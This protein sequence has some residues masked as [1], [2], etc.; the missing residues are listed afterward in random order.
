MR[1]SS[2][3][4]WLR[5][6]SSPRKTASKKPYFRKC[7]LEIL[8]DRTL[9]SAQIYTVT[10]NGDAG[11]KDTSDPSGHSGDVRYCINQANQVA[12]AGS[13]I[14]FDP[15]AIFG[16]NPTGTI[17][18]SHG[19]LPVK[20]N[21]TIQG[22]SVGP[23]IVTIS[24]I[25]GG[26]ASR[27]FDITSSVAKV[28]ISDLTIADGNAEPANS[29]VP[30]NQGGDIFNGGTLVLSNDI[31]TN[32]LSVGTVGG[33]NGRG[34]AIYNAEGTSGI[35]S[36]ATLILDNTIVEN[37]VARGIAG[38]IAEGGGVLN[39]INATLIVQNGSQI[40]NNQAIGATLDGGAA[41]GGGILNFGA[42]QLNGSSSAPIVIADNLAQG[43]TGGNGAHG[44]TPQSGPGGKGGDGLNGGDA[45][46]GGIY[47]VGSTFTLQ[48]VHF[49]GNQANAG[50]G[51][52]GGTG[53]NAAGNGFSG[54][55]GGKG[56]KGGSA[57]GGGIYNG[58]SALIVPN[59]QFG[60]D[61]NGVGN[62]VNSG[63]G[64]NGGNGGNGTSGAGGGVGGKGTK[65]GDG[66]QALGGAM[67]NFGGSVSFTN[68]SFTSSLAR[69]GG[70]GNSGSGGSGGN[71]TNNGAKGAKGGLGADGGRGGDA[72]GGGLFNE[73]SKTSYSL[74]MTNGTFAGNQAVAGAGGAGGAGGLAG[75]GG[76]GNATLTGGKGGSGS[77][78]GA[79][80]AGGN[81][82]GGGFYNTVGTV[83]IKG[84]SL[85]DNSV[86][87]G[88]GGAGGAAGNGG[89]GG[90]NTSAG[91]KAG[92]G[93]KG[94]AGGLGGN[95]G[96]AEGG[97]AG[98]QGGNMTVTGADFL[99]NLIHTST[100][101]TG[102]NGGRGGNGGNGTAIGLNGYGGTGGNGGEGGTGASALGGG[103]FV[104]AS[105][106]TVTNSIFG[107]SG[108]SNQIVGGAGGAG[109]IGGSIGIHGH[110][111]T[112]TTYGTKSSLLNPAGDGGQGGLG[113]YV[114]GGALAVTGTAETVQISGST[115]A[116]NSITSGDGGAG[117][118]GG[119]FSVDGTKGGI[120]GQGGN[121]GL[122]QGGAISLSA[123]TA[124][125][126]TL[127]SDTITTNSAKGG[128]GGAG[129]INYLPGAAVFVIGWNGFGSN[130]GNGGDGG[131]QSATEPYTYGGG[132]GGAG[133]QVLG[134]GVY[135][136]NNS[137]ASLSFR[138]NG[139]SASSN[140][141]TGGSAGSGGNAGASG[142]DNIPGGA[143][144]AG[145]AVQGGGL[146]VTAGSNAIDTTSLVDLTLAGNTITGGAGGAGG[147]GYNATGG[148][149]GNAQGGAVFTT[150]ANTTSG[151][152]STLGVTGSTLSGNQANGGLGGN[153]GSSTTPNGG[154]GGA[155]GN[156]GNADGAGLYNGDNTLMNVINSTFGGSASSGNPPSLNYNVLS[157]GLGGSGGD[158]GTATGVVKSNGGAGGAGGSV[159]GA[160]VYNAG[161][162]AI[163]INDTLVYGQ[164]VVFGIGAPGGSGAG[165]GG[166]PGAPG[167]AGT[168]LAGGYYAADA[169]NQTNLVGNSIIDLNAAAT[170]SPDV[171]GTF[172]SFGNN[173][174]GSTAGATGFIPTDQSNISAA[175][176][177]LG[178]LQNNGG[179]T[180]TDALLNNSQGKSIAIDTG[181]NLLV[182]TTFFN[183]FGTNPTDQRGTGFP[184][185][186]SPSGT[187]MV[188]VGAFEYEP[189]G[190]GGPILTDPGNQT[191]NEGDKVS[192]AIKAQNA[193]T[194]SAI[195][196]PSG[197][198]I[199]TTTGVISGTIGSYAAGSYTVTVFA[200]HNGFLSS[201]TFTWTVN[202]TTPP[203]LTV[204]SNQSNNEGDKV[205]LQI[206]AVDADTFTATGLPPGLSINNSGLITGT[207]SQP[208]DGTYTVTI[209]VTDTDNIIPAN[210][211][212]TKS[213]TWTVADN[214]P[215]SVTSPGNQSNNEGDKV[216]LQIQA[217]DADTFTATGLPP[218]LTISKTGL[219]SGTISQP[220]DGTYTVTIIGKD[221]D[222]TT[223]INT[224][225]VTFTWTVADN[226]PPS[227]TSPGNQSNKEGDKVSLQIQSVDADSIT[228]KGL[229]PGLT[230]SSSG[231]ITG[232]I[233]QPGDGTYTVTITAT[234]SDNPTSNKTTTI[235]FTWTV[236][237]N[238]PPV[239]TNPSTQNNNEGD[240]VKLAI[241][242]KD[243]D[244]FSATNLPTGLSINATTGV[245]SGTIDPRAAG[246]YTVTVKA[247]DGGNSSSVTFTWNVA[248]TTPPDI[249]NPGTQ[250]NN[251]GDSVNLAIK[252]V[253]NDPGT[254]TAT[255]LP[256][257]LSIDATTG[258]ITGNI[259]PR[260]EG[261]YSVTVTAS[262][263]G[264]PA[265]VTF[266]W[267]V[268]DTTPPSFTVSNQTSD[269]GAVISL[270]T[271]PED[272]DPGS[273]TATG[274]P[275]GLSINA[276][277][278]LITG[279]I[280]PRG[281]GTYTVT[282]KA[283][284]GNISGSTTF[285][286]TVNDTTPP[287][288]TVSDQT[289]D[290]GTVIS[291]ATN[292]DDADA[293]SITATGLPAGLSINATTGVISGTIDPRAAGTYTVILQ[294]AD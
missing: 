181:N 188:D 43:G 12:N 279:T 64:G 257:G 80:G 139:G 51:G 263:N 26:G 142:E 193:D 228:A 124:Q 104:G 35:G 281:A 38:G 150:S 3:R 70:A 137:S 83:T 76:A 121:G 227:V 59:V 224:A 114:Y 136:S 219:I 262:D 147:A 144:G 134:G 229:P 73:P 200:T 14:E 19:E 241:Q 158:A 264:H 171:L 275:K 8:E 112:P 65:A 82:Q 213:F 61:A 84:T 226:L 143:G 45:L 233:S 98:N 260:G 180:S 126:A 161:T 220:G 120:N 256:P 110:G 87:S 131:S 25:G 230:I 106:L 203:S 32:G 109:G 133:G 240:T 16:G 94:G 267:N 194:F 189:T 123:T 13:T 190:T 140:T 67:A 10:L 169:A 218:G 167:V 75:N 56:G 184:R 57:Q 237:D 160:N 148:N 214:L 17:S 102:G 192:L 182:T 156:G 130:A 258:V 186:Y 235:T 86:G 198:S 215:P 31:V 5:R 242:A 7:F 173:I 204:P 113:A 231:L 291:L 101:G 175:Q 34:G 277:T 78:G 30:G 88:A 265:S 127:N 179:L 254:F 177:N 58:T 183:L 11:T 40:V 79:G 283:T 261:T 125:S 294:A 41:E 55:P 107:E 287:S 74:S 146:Y 23:T 36:G 255:G 42:I 68:T 9:L 91:K 71:S 252:A 205:S 271:N 210:K 28:T 207:L 163:F 99:S 286:W 153:A 128:K 52:N 77:A 202:D 95:A 239:L 50:A 119:M 29:S 268:A 33:P 97:A 129:T 209:T 248:D 145:G 66:G 141:L 48:Y 165:I 89:Q 149:G 197:L 221:S 289:N 166:Q 53:G 234:D 174:L 27:I 21:M 243:A 39:D 62:E 176:L 96:L 211:S 22:A 46:G 37:S 238:L 108:G 270:A 135:F 249:T 116:S 152:N 100:G 206:Q 170:N 162:T 69:A 253:D 187:P 246:T 250:T 244:S 276:N 122:A 138:V 225:S 72:E 151:Q 269:E 217:V 247:V 154:D 196:L 236:E 272:A 280:D 172:I 103:L 20:V 85:T 105:N 208:S 293:G 273:I 54:G 24:G 90:D 212:V 223:S 60:T 168:G 117:G 164:A 4:K 2:W 201:T 178:P 222:N 159:F 111:Q 251:E 245:I 285:T 155:G 6:S 132:A 195:G 93:G 49:L 191:N 199:N 185:I 292:P 288:F 44:S 18:L 63:A 232:T 278:G 284:D 157:G 216:S 92:A 274:L 81:A 259:D 118:P 15:T 47:N 115:F 266:T 290:E 1:L 282:L